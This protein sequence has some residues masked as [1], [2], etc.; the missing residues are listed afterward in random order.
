MVSPFFTD[1]FEGVKRMLSAASTS[2]VRVTLAATP[3][4]PM[5][6]SS[7]PPPWVPP[8]KTADAANAAAAKTK[9]AREARLNLMDFMVVLGVLV[10]E[11]VEEKRC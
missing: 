8:A 9:P 1:T 11:T 4:S 10:G 2:I 5:G 7:C 3:G 6:D